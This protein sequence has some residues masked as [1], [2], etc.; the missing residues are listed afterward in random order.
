MKQV[1]FSI[2][3]TVYNKEDF[4]GEAIQ[5]VLGQSYQDF[6]LVIVDDGSSDESWRIARKFASEDSRVRIFRNNCNLGDYPNRNKAMSLAKNEYL[7]FLDADDVMA[8][9]ALETYAKAVS[10]V[11]DDEPLYYVN[12]PSDE[13]ELPRLMCLNSKQ[14]YRRAYI[15]RER[16]FG[17]APNSCLY[18]KSVI[19]RYGAFQADRLT[20]DYEMAHRLAVYGS[21]GILETPEYLAKW[22]LHPN[23]ESQQSRSDLSLA[24]DYLRISKSYLSRVSDFFSSAELEHIYRR[25]AHEEAQL[26]R[27]AIGRFD[28][29]A[30]FKV[31]RNLNYPLLQLIPLLFSPYDVNV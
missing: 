12:C 27:S 24:S 18:R 7:K 20:G 14:A 19:E 16:M 10:N 28:V 1:K 6:E 23:Q 9:C 25:Q 29:G 17:A 3:T 22:R 8:P 4:L 30:L 13:V 21:I 2:L 11:S 15:D 26:L 5:S 31:K